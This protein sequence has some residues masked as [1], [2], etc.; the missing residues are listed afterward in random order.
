MNIKEYIKDKSFHLSM[1][2]LMIGIIFLFMLVFQI[3]QTYIIFLIS[4]IVFFS[5][6]IFIY[7]YL[8]Q[9]SFYQYYLQQLEQLDQKYL[10][11]EMIKKPRFLHGKILYQSLYDINKS[12]N[13]RINDLSFQVD[14]FKDYIEMWIH[15][16]KIPLSHLILIMHNHKSEMSPQ[17]LE[18]V[19][20][21]ENQV[22]LVLYYVRCENAQNDYLIKSSSLLKI[23]NHVIVK[24]KDYFIYHKLKLSLKDL[25]YDVYTDS[26]W[27]EFIVNQIINNSFQYSGHKDD[28]L[29]EISAC[30]K[31]HHIILSIYDNGIGISSSDLPR[32][33]EK[34]FT[35]DNGRFQKKSTGMGLYI[36]Y[37]LCQ[38]LG[39]Q[40]IIESKQNEYTKVSI[41]FC[42]NDYYDVVR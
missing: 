2:V 17:V 15:E 25:N 38:R 9:V 4:I 18:Q 31:D 16:V 22:N 41:V 35:G 42:L 11:C 40:L 24:N 19:R 5:I 34:S 32:V 33:F 1:F 39:H 29:I 3:S 27:L 6:I 37:Q 23:V 21:L 7:D 13:E 30:Q 12:M 28:S 14:D 8:R 10:I 20:I 26:K 36:C